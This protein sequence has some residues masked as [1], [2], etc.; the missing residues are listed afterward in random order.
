MV[1]KF[2]FLYCSQKIEIYYVIIIAM[3]F[4]K[5]H[6]FHQI[7]V[8]IL[9]PVDEQLIKP[10][11]FGP[12]IS[13]R[14]CLTVV[15]KSDETFVTLDNNASGNIIK[16]LFAYI[17]E[18]NVKAL[19]IR[20]ITVLSDSWWYLFGLIRESRILKHL[21]L[22]NVFQ[23]LDTHYYIT[24]SAY[25]YHS[26][27]LTFWYTNNSKTMISPDNYQ[28]I[29]NRYL[30]TI[31]VNTPPCGSFILSYTDNIATYNNTQN[32]MILLLLAN[33]KHIGPIGSI[34]RDVLLLILKLIWNTYRN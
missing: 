23:D 1:I 6:G 7:L 11:D 15:A 29:N 32:V 20:D 13:S 25:I 3:D 4:C 16:Q 28:T 27:L 17:S 10:G 19:E 21:C 30:H 34:P 31:K 8:N 2:N 33:K 9:K 22:Y 26:R 5:A 24:T 14:L 18:Y 12:K